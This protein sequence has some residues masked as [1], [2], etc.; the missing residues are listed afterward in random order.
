MR[1]LCTIEDRLN[2][3]LRSVRKAFL[4]END[5]F[6]NCT[7]FESLLEY[8]SSLPDFSLREFNLKPCLASEQ[9]RSQ[10]VR[11]P[12]KRKSH[13]KCGAR[14]F[15]RLAAAYCLA[16]YIYDLLVSRDSNFIFLLNLKISLLFIF[17]P[18]HTDCLTFCYNVIYMFPKLT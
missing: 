17:T 3:E 6:L 12:E 9:G 1:N 8:A 7:V 10:G 13:T 11:S 5:D 16:S 15:G 4:P 2:I 14:H 18:L